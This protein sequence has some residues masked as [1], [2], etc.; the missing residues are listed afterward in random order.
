[1]ENTRIESVN[2]QHA[3]LNVLNHHYISFS[4]LFSVQHY[5]A[6]YCTA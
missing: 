2:K 1:M 6:E 5:T 3:P 4:W